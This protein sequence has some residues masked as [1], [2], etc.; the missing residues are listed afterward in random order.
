MVTLQNGGARAAQLAR[1]RISAPIRL[2]F[3]LSLSAVQLVYKVDS[4]G[5]LCVNV[6]RQYTQMMIVAGGLRSPDVAV[7][8]DIIRGAGFG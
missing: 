6:D 8:L 4:D 3:S 5:D 7:L 1:C 2:F